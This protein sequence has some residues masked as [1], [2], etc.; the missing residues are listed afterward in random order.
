MAVGPVGHVMSLA[1]KIYTKPQG[2][3]VIFQKTQ[4]NFCWEKHQRPA[5][6]LEVTAMGSILRYGVSKPELRTCHIET[7]C[8]HRKGIGLCFCPS[9]DRRIV[10]IVPGPSKK[11]PSKWFPVTKINH[12]LKPSEASA[13]KITSQAFIPGAEQVAMLWNFEAKCVG[14]L[15]LS[16][17]RWIKWT[18]IEQIK[19]HRLGLEPNGIAQ[20]RNERVMKSGKEYLIK[21]IIDYY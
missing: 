11:C 21:S 10:E 12:R 4:S 5:P 6:P 15:K 9:K 1:W 2:Y 17:A 3:L 18:C 13:E 16:Y 8:H 7:S 14:P 19:Q 20:K